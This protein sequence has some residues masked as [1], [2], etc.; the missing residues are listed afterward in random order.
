[1]L[2]A[3]RTVVTGPPQFCMRAIAGESASVRLRTKWTGN[4]VRSNYAK[5]NIGSG[6]LPG[7][8][9]LPPG[10]ETDARRSEPGTESEEMSAAESGAERF[11]KAFLLLLVASISAAFLATI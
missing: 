7:A 10:Q 8:R 3:S 2:A 1:M 4:G 11:R 5:V 9:W 6:L